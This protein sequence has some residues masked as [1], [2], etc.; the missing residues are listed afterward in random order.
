MTGSRAS[1]F[2][3][4][5]VRRSG[6]IHIQPY[7]RRRLPSTEDKPKEMPGTSVVLCPLLT[8]KVTPMALLSSRFLSSPT[9]GRCPMTCS[10]QE[11][12]LV[13]NIPVQKS[14]VEVSPQANEVPFRIRFRDC[15]AE[16]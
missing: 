4:Q 12:A 7:T 11:L 8:W 15:A 13:R 5:I 6:M 9:W 16:D 2:F 10:P 3:S 1:W 14:D